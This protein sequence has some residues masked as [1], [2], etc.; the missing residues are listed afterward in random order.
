[1]THNQAL[2][3][4]KILVILTYEWFFST[5]KKIDPNN[6]TESG[7]VQ[8]GLPDVELS[9][10]GLPNAEEIESENRPPRQPGTRRK[11]L[12][13]RKVQKNRQAADQVRDS[14]GKYYL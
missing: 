3:N 13:V 9:K 12:T 5:F 2:E 7:L 4:L 14:Y 11:Y 8:A 6:E 1:M 10:T